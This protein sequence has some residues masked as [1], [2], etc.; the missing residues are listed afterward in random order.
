MLAEYQGTA[1][2]H[3]YGSYSLDIPTEGSGCMRT[4]RLVVIEFIPGLSMQK[5]DPGTL[6]QAT[7]QSVMKSAI[8]LETSDHAKD[9]LLGDLTPRN[10]MVTDPDPNSEDRRLVFIDSGDAE[11]G[12]GAVSEQKE[13][14]A[15]EFHI[16]HYAS[17][18][19]RWH[20][21][22]HQNDPRVDW[23]DWY[24][25]PWLQTEFADTAAAITPGMLEYYMPYYFRQEWEMIWQRGCGE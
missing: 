17:P 7:R 15:F 3:H 6:T 13:S 20:Y 10:V 1:I 8:E 21:G 9:V 11:V 14:R 4:V 2:P 18:L 12:C 5:I 22:Q 16:D 24:W 25:Q 23:I 19:L